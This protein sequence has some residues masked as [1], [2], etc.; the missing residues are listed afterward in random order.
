MLVKLMIQK[1]WDDDNFLSGDDIRTCLS[2]SK[3][4]LSPSC[5]SKLLKSCFVEDNKYDIEKISSTIHK[6]LYLLSPSVNH[7]GKNDTHAWS[8]MLNLY[9]NLPKLSVDPED[10]AF[11]KHSDETKEKLR[12][13][14]LLHEGCDEGHLTPDDVVQLCLAYCTVHNIGVDTGNIRQAVNI[15]RSHSLH[16]GLVSVNIFIQNLGPS[17]SNNQ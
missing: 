13:A 7:D 2:L 9:N 17:S 8:Q 16:R 15:A 5:I 1:D 10:E 4:N 3:I 14:M 11:K 12:S 6:A